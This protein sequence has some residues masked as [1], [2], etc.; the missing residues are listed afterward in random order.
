VKVESITRVRAYELARPV[1]VEWVDEISQ[2]HVGTSSL[3]GG[4]VLD[5]PP[6][7]VSQGGPTARTSAKIRVNGREGFV[8]TTRLEE[9]LP[10]WNSTARHPLVTGK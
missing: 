6:F 4:T 10:E 5:L 3:A 1:P 7:V 2:S 8:G 9:A